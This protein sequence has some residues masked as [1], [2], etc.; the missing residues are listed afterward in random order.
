[1]RTSILALLALFALIGMSVAEYST[2]PEAGLLLKENKNMTFDESQKVNGIG[3]FSTYE[4]ALMP[5]ALGKG[6]ESKNKVHGSGR[7]EAESQIYG[8]NNNLVWINLNDDFVM[9]DFLPSAY[10]LIANSTIHMKEN[11]N[12]TYNPMAMTIGTRY[13][14]AHPIAFNSLLTDKTWIKNYGGLASGVDPTSMN[15][16][17][18]GAHGLDVAL[19]VQ[20]N[21]VQSTVVCPIEVTTMKVQ[22]DLIDGKAHF[23]VLQLQ[24]N[25][26]VAKKWQ[27]PLTYVDEDYVGSYH[28]MKNMAMKKIAPTIL[29]TYGWLPCSC[30]SGWDDMVIHDT[31]YQSAKGFF[32]CTTC[33]PPA[34]CSHKS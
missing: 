32:D 5:N 18:E 3:F 28:L 21:N 29:T 22:E 14:A 31:R 8:N 16:M 20:A 24:G 4:Y 6:V 11:N 33:W 34:S 7:I 10:E 27:N 9:E 12:M 17:A 30:N 2:G 26:E 19:E 13:Y 1:M 25:G 23:G 15:H